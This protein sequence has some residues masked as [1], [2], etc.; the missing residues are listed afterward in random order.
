L[1]NIGS[2]RALLAIAPSMV[3]RLSDRG[4]KVAVILYWHSDRLKCINDSRV[5]SDIVM[6]Q[7]GGR[8][9]E[10]FGLGAMRVAMGTRDLPDRPWFPQEVA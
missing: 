6:R 3:P 2:I 10:R 7:F 9:C 8:F 4:M 5:N 1:P